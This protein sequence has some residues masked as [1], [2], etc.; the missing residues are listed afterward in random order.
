[1]SADVQGLASVEYR[2]CHRYNCKSNI[3]IMLC[4]LIALTPEYEKGSHG[5]PFHI[6]ANG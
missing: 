4:M 1:M 5:S 2:C 6:M 3:Y